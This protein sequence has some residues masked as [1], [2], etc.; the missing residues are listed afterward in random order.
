MQEYFSVEALR[1]L[2]WGAELF[3]YNHVNTP[4]SIHRNASID[5]ASSTFREDY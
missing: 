3:S 1:E 5:S 4:D 2:D